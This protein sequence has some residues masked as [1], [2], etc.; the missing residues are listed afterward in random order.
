MKS[1][2]ACFGS[3]MERPASLI[4][5]KGP[6]TG[7]EKLIALK[8]ERDLDFVVLYAAGDVDGPLAHEMRIGVSG[9]KAFD[10]EMKAL[11]T[12]RSTGVAVHMA[13]IIS[14]RAA[15]GLVRSSVEDVLRQLGR[16]RRGSWWIAAPDE[17][18]RLVSASADI[19]RVALM[20][21]VDADRREREAINRE[22]D[23]MTGG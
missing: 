10:E 3:P 11:R 9:R 14:G 12:Y 4:P 19:H 13:H 15:A 20:T 8:V 18:A 7:V 2:A 17:A 21:G 6:A 23:L 1:A 16:H 5:S 22:M